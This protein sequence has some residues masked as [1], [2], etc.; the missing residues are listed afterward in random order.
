VKQVVTDIKERLFA[1]QFVRYVIVGV[2]NNTVGYLTFLLMAYF[3]V[4]P[5]LAMTIVY[6]I[7]ASLGFIGHKK[8]SFS[9]EGL[10]LKTGA[11][12]IVAHSLAY[13]LNLFLLYYFF[14]LLGYPYQL[15]QAG[16]MVV[17]VVF[18]YTMFRFFV[19]R[20]TG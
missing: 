16:V 1:E 19:F 14:N 6:L 10:F 3:G 2:L 8:W 12:Y 9:H 5:K 18:L 11:R 17:L 7:F 4:E 15:V 13:L 20:S